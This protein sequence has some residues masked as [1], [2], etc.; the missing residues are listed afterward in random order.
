[1]EINVRSTFLFVA[2][3]VAVSLV[4]TDAFAEK[5]ISI[6]MGQDARCEKL[7][8]SGKPASGGY[9]VENVS[10]KKDGIVSVTYAEEMGVI[11]FEPQSVGNTKVRVSGQRYEL[12]R[13]D[14]VKS[15][16]RFYR[17]FRVRVR[18]TKTSD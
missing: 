8:P 18:P 4:A 11:C 5:T 16:K 3:L 14:R 7:S 10:V 13:N 15:S 1:V 6:R 2:L 9:K 17:A 12:E